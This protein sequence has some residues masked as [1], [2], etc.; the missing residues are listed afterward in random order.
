MS[1]SSPRL[2]YDDFAKTAP[3]VHAGLLAVGKA[4]AESGLDKHLVEF[5]QMRASQIN[6]CAFCL[7][8]HLNRAHKL[9][10]A[11][12]KLD[13]LATWREAGLFSESE[14]AALA[15]TEALTDVAHKG[16]SQ[17]EYVELLKHF[18]QAQVAFLTATIGLIN[19]WN[20]IG[21]AFGFAPP[22]PRRTG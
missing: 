16:A 14:A 15:W 4:I 6:G 10:I 5:V 12:E 20:R 17:A 3:A 18:D 22:I 9:G 1:A 8:H 11:Q 2:S 21:V 13:L 7:Q 19:N